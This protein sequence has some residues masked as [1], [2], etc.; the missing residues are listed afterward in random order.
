MKLLFGKRMEHDTGYYSE[1]PFT[2]SKKYKK[3]PETQKEVSQKMT[4]D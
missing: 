4:K 2:A 3:Q 1:S